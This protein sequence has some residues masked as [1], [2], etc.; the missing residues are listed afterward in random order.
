MS[1]ND[2][3]L[4]RLK[5]ILASDMPLTIVT[6]EALIARLE[7]AE[8]V[9]ARVREGMPPFNRALEYAAPAEDIYRALDGD[10]RG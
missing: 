2:I 6:T 8:A 5:D 3:P 4:G 1:I 10:T 7:Q 9:V